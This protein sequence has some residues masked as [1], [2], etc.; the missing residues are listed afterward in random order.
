MDHKGVSSPDDVRATL[1]ALMGD[2]GSCL[3][4]GHVVRTSNV[5]ERHRIYSCATGQRRESNVSR[6]NANFLFEIV[7]IFFQSAFRRP[8]G[9]ST[10]SVCFK[11]GEHRIETAHRSNTF[12]QFP[13][14]R[15]SMAVGMARFDWGCDS[16]MVG[17]DSVG[18]YRP[19]S[20]ALG[21]EDLFD[22]SVANGK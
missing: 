6:D 22:R 18:R 19:L 21:L 5:M 4:S 13:D 14:T 11:F 2:V 9:I 20:M 7:S 15:G 16:R 1:F 8:L 10:D 17:R 3:D 12:D